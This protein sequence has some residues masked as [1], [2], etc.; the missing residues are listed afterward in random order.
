MKE[1]RFRV[2][3]I[4]VEKVLEGLISKIV[5]NF[6]VKEIIL[7]GSYSWGKPDKNSDLDIVVILDEEGYSKSFSEKI[8]KK[9]KVS[10]LILDIKRKFPLDLLV[11]TK[12]EWNR[13]IEPGFSFFKEINEN[14]IRIYE[15]KN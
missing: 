9:E 7:F 15:R 2:H 1:K 5:N 13:L 12:Y 14:G 3:Q 10:N 6:K 8:G 11:Y 4:E